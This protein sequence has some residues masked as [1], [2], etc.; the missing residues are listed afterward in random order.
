MATRRRTHFDDR[1]LIVDGS[2]LPF[3]AGAMHYWRMNPSEWKPCLRSLRSLGLR[4]VDTYVPWRVHKDFTGPRDLSRF[5]AE[6]ADADLRVVLR[7]GPT[8]NAELTA[9][10]LPDHVLA[11]PFH[12][13]TSRNT[14]AW[15]PAPPRAFPIPSYA[16]RAFHDEVRAWYA[17]VAK[18]V[19]PHISSIAAISVDN[20]TQHFFRLGAFDLD[21]HPDAIAWW[22]E[23][24]DVDPPRD[25]SSPH[26]AAWIRFKDHYTARAL[27]L[28]S[29]YLDDVGLDAA[30]VHNLPPTDPTLYDLPS[31]A[32]AIDGIAGIDAYSPRSAFAS[33]RRR[34]LHCAG[35]SPLPLALE[36]GVGFTPFLP[37]I[38][39]PDHDRDQ[40]LT[41]LAAGIRGFNLYMAVE[42]DRFYGAAIDRT[43]KINAPWIA[44][45]LATL[46]AVDWPSL[47]RRANL[48]LVLSRADVRHGTAT[49]SPLTP[50]VLDALGLSDLATD[51]G[52][53]SHRRWFTALESALA[54]AS[55]T[56]S[57]T[58]TPTSPATRRSSSPPTTASTPPSSLASVLPKQ[59]WSSAR[60]H[61]PA[62]S[63]T[64]PSPL[65]PS[66]AASAPAP[67]TISP[68]SRP[69]S[70]PS[71]A[72]P[73]STSSAP[74]TSS[75]PPSSTRPTRPA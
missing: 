63:S 18:H 61:P 29:S 33:L 32:T 68:P 7:P 49:T 28:F 54:R 52:A 24:D 65:S 14:P 75:R 26:A 15:F 73:R 66:T 62:T 20:E 19:L 57:S 5:L 25:A 22:R 40:L 51:A 53:L 36:A 1:G 10:G 43:G 48:A 27:S 34:A 31:T 60:A 3:Y 12:A 67:S 16:S 21:Y 64:G 42:R 11:P 9:F 69:T 46:D 2:H 6:A 41:L 13:L 47:R 58:R 74:R 35:S 38:T 72:T 8:V 59:P 39:D 37:P 30:H 23:L 70:P 45:L 17:T 4:L 56:T 55:P 71:P 44:P 50:V